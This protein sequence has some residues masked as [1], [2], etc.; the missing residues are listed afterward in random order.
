MDLVLMILRYFMVFVRVQYWVLFV[1]YLF[2]EHIHALE[3]A[4]YRCY[5]GFCFVGVLAYADDFVLLAPSPN[6]TMIMVKI[7][8]GFGIRYFVIF[9]DKSKCLLCLS[10]N[11]TYRLPHATTAVFYIGSNVIECVNEWS[12]LGHVISTSCDDMHDLESW[13]PCLIGQI[14]GI[15]CAYRNVT[16]N[17]K[18][19]LFTTYCTSLYGA[20][21][22]DLSNDYI[23]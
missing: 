6:A 10:P 18:I 2:Y 7:S 21:L 19:R 9:N 20:E 5:I 22:W 13:K 15:L 8:D 3:S 11:R 23:H 17:T 1:L 12:H 4:N 16:C 14:N